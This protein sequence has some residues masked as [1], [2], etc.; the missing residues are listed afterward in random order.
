MKFCYVDESGTHSDPY[1]VMAGIIVD[2]SRM[3][4]T[5]GIWF[6]FLDLISEV[7]GRRIEEFHARELYGGS[8]EWHKI[9][10]AERK[11]IITAVIKWLADRKHHV[12]WSAIDNN[13]W[14]RLKKTESRL[15]ELGNPWRTAAFHIVL[16]LQKRFQS[17]SKTKGHTVCV[18]D[19]KSSEEKDFPKF[20][21]RPPDWSGT[22]YSHDSR[23]RPLDQ[24]VDVPHFVDSELAVLIQIADLVAYILRRFTELKNGNSERYKGEDQTIQDWIHSIQERAIPSKD[25]YLKRGRCETMN[26]FWNLAPDC[27]RN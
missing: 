1:L 20:I 8:G 18:F 27:L 16:T 17:E 19:H 21:C 26:L 6:D 12:T 7:A 24:I 25:R 13:I 4:V 23:K 2:A 22:Y 3:H 9:D 14:N 10:G 11:K 15:Q 5:K